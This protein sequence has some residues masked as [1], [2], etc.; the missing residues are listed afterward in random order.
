LRCSGVYS[1]IKLLSETVAS[2]PVRL[3][4]SETKREVKDHPVAELLRNPNLE[5]TPP[6]FWEMML[7]NYFTWGIGYC[8][9]IESNG[10]VSQLWP[11]AAGHTEPVRVNGRLVYHYTVPDT[12]QRVP[13]NSEDMMAF[14]MF[15]MTSNLK[16][17]APIW[18]AQRAIELSLSIE[19]AVTENF[20]D[21]VRPDMIVNLPP[22]KALER[23]ED[24]GADFLKEEHLKIQN[25]IAGARTRRELYL[26]FG[27]SS[28]PYAANYQQAQ[29]SE[30]RDFQILEFCRIWRVPPSKVGVS[31]SVTR[32]NAEQ[33]NL[34]F[35]QDTIRPILA[36]FQ[37]RL[38]R[39]LL[40]GRDRERLSIRFVPRAILRGDIKTQTD[41]YTRLWQIGAL[42][43]NQILGFEDLPPLDDPRADQP[44][45]PVN[46]TTEQIG[47]ADQGGTN[48]EA[49]AEAAALKRAWESQISS[50]LGS[51]DDERHH[52][53]TLVPM[54]DELIEDRRLLDDELNEQCELRQAFE[55]ENDR[56]FQERQGL[57]AE[58]AVL[59]AE[60]HGLTV[61]IAA[62]KDS[63]NAVML[64]GAPTE[65]QKR[66][67]KG[68]KAASEGVK[69]A[70]AAA[71]AKVVRKEKAVVSK[72]AASLIGKRNVAGLKRRIKALY[73]PDGELTGFLADNVQALVRAL[74]DGIVAEI[75][76]ET[77]GEFTTKDLDKMHREFTRIYVRDYTHSSLFQLLD[78]IEEAEG[79]VLEAIEQRLDEWENGTNADNPTRAE[80][81]SAQQTHKGNSVFTKGLYVLAGVANVLITGGT[82]EICAPLQGVYKIANAPSPGFHHGCGCD[83]V[84]A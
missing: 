35:Y 75:R 60:R 26:P 56:L 62:I 20:T 12:G 51:L 19:H 57:E 40:I 65:K 11:L 48:E 7:A 13:I 76:K 55:W 17:H 43:T 22:E 14:R 63:P 72:D 59:V 70:F 58:N 67:L 39:D 28:T 3:I 81:E 25:Q 44:N 33:D 37:S 54:L 4:E 42:T 29:V 5:Q 32:V 2:L 31:S 52:S 82:C 49:R 71:I 27:Y 84:S 74:L 50:L 53:D 9:K 24:L 47:G 38:E 80:K 30:V 68:R 77:G 69:G 45:W 8:E 16:A 36:K 15:G 46:T 23:L 1:P 73:S 18:M 10:F 78:A 41:Q 6:E 66:S 21:G 61:Q 83:L 64:R 79:D 34:S